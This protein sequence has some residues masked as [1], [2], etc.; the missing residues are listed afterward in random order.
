MCD[1]HYH[2]YNFSAAISAAAERNGGPIEESQRALGESKKTRRHKK[3]AANVRIP[4]SA[5]TIIILVFYCDL[6]HITIVVTSHLAIPDGL[7]L[8]VLP[9]SI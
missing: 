4:Q 3:T 1:A 2:K 6:T 9:V 7:F 5:R 8:H